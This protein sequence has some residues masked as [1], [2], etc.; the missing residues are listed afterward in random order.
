[1]AR[2]IAAA[3]ARALREDAGTET[4]HFHAGPQGQPYACHDAR[5]AS[6]RLD[7]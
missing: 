6:P 2:R 1:M 3:I 7:A 4:V 5:C